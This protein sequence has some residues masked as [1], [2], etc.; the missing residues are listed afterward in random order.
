LSSTRDDELNYRNKYDETY[1]LE[2]EADEEISQLIEPYKDRKSYEGDDNHDFRSD[3]HL[4]NDN[5]LENLEHEHNPKYFKLKEEKQKWTRLLAELLNDKKNVEKKLNELTNISKLA[6]NINKRTMY[7]P[8]EQKLTSIAGDK[9]MNEEF[10]LSER[11]SSKLNR[12][13]NTPYIFKSSSNLFELEDIESIEKSQTKTHVDETTKTVSTRKTKS[14]ATNSYKHSKTEKIPIKSKPK[15]SKRV[16]NFL[17]RSQSFNDLNGINYKNINKH[18]RTSFDHSLNKLSYIEILHHQNKNT[19]SITNKTKKCKLNK[20]KRNNS[21]C[22]VCM[23]D[24]EL[25]RINNTKSVSLREE[26]NF[27]I[28]DTIEV[29]PL[30]L[31]RQSNLKAYA[32]TLET[33]KGFEQSI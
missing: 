31:K 8:I 25:E 15:K 16:K 21:N 18:H 11:S 13:R 32:P 33:L 17:D 4:S 1:N 3:W 28:Q 23:T 6:Q 26:V 9:S 7:K 19:M 14:S 20:D 22:E 5:N 24:R 30:K 27:N 29:L 2:R 12:N 10:I